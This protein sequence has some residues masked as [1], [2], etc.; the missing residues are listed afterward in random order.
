MSNLLLRCWY[1]ATQLWCNLSCEA[2]EHGV[3]EGWP[4]VEE[5][6]SDPEFGV[7]TQLVE[8]DGDARTV[9]EWGTEEE[10]AT[11]RPRIATDFGTVLVQYLGLGT[12]G[13]RSG[14][15][16]VPDIGVLGDD[17]EQ[18]SLAAAA[19]DNRK[20]GLK[21]LGPEAGLP[22]GI[23][24][25]AEGDCLLRPEPAED[26]AGLCEPVHPFSDGWQRDPILL[27]GV[28]VPGCAEA[29][30]EPATRDLV[31]RR[32]HG[33]EER[34]MPVDDP[35]D[36][37]GA[38]DPLRAGRHGR[39]QSG[40]LEARP[41]VAAVGRAKVV[42]AG[43]P[44]ESELLAAFGQLEEGIGAR[45]RLAGVDT[46]SDVAVVETRDDLFRPP[47]HALDHSSIVVAMSPP[48]RSRQAVS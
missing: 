13:V 10:G 5:E 8:A 26:F 45:I 16:R 27:L 18:P 32:G 35:V 38:A 41:I 12:V 46:Y 39:N 31:D 22:Q 40:A 44:V 7:G 19:D 30:L 17:A 28:V 15:R 9:G 2:L 23:V 42:E 20:P 34:R 43:D 29:D 36:Q 48:C 1:Q 3:V 21:R 6:V 33:G 14:R 24:A 25:S 47:F 37:G 4:Q 11:D